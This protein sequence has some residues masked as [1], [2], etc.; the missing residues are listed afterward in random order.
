MR[1]EL[2]L[3]RPA[4]Q[5]KPALVAEGLSKPKARVER[6]GLYEVT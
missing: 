5:D 1:K 3:K 6:L 4:L 2:E